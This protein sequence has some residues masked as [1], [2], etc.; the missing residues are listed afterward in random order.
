MSQLRRD[1]KTQTYLWIDP[2]P[3]DSK[4]NEKLVEQSWVSHKNQ[5]LEQGPT[6]ICVPPHHA[7]GGECQDE[8]VDVD[9]YGT[10]LGSSRTADMGAF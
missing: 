4:K 5:S 2:G 8:I 3:G 10:L 1:I 9:G 6:S 7:F